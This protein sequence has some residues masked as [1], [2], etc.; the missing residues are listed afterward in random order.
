VLSQGGD[1]LSVGERWQAVALGEELRDPQTGNSLGRN[2][3]PC[4]TIRIDRVS[5]QTSYGTL[6]EGVANLGGIN[7]RPGAIELRSK[8][9]PAKA[10]AVASAGQAVAAQR[11]ARAAAPKQ[12][13]AAK[14]N[15]DSNW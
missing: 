13:E 10:Q 2:E 6:E 11:Q 4:C 5:N 7:F 12:A 1:T 14:A 15:D 8:A 3:V 9:A